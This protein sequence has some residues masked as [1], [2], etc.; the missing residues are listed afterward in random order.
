MRILAAT[1][2]VVAL[3]FSQTPAHANPY[4]SAPAYAKKAPHSDARIKPF[5]TAGDSIPLTGGTG[6]YLVVGIPD[7]LGLYRNGNHVILLSNHEFTDKQGGPVGPLPGGA[8]VSEFTLSIGKQGAEGKITVLSGKAAIDTIVESGRRVTSTKR[9]FG[10]LCSATLADHR[11]GFDRPILMTTEELSAGSTFDSLGGQA[12]ALIGGSIY[13][14]PWLGRFR[15]ENRV[16]VPFTGSKTVAF[17]LEDDDRDGQS[18]QLYMFVGEKRPGVAGALAV[19]GLDKGRLYVFAAADA[20]IHNESYFKVERPRGSKPPMPSTT[21]AT[22]NGRWMPIDWDLTDSELETTVTSRA[23]NAFTFVRVEDG[24]A[25]PRKAGEFWFVTTGEKDHPVNPF[26]RL[27]RLDFDPNDPANNP[28]RLTLALVGHSKGMV[29]P[30]NID[31]NTHG[32]IAIC[33][34]PNYDFQKDLGLARRDARFWIYNIDEKSLTAVAELDRDAARAHALAAGDSTDR[35][36]DKPGG[37]EFSGVVDAEDY[38]GRGAWILDVQAH[39]LRIRPRETVEGGQYL[40]V[41][42]KPKEPR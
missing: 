6:K 3:A 42:W 11:V 25:N 27:Y 23:V 9:R 10:K 37:W 24:A 41:I 39:S 7:G 15:G 38:L 18:S 28:A 19:N 17:S 32:E 29:S 2:M 4:A 20:S 31:I 36:K 8:R 5:L 12:Y 14:L 30:D 22:L 40:Q 13:A 26:G 21:T 35:R 33:E 34:D 16:P 1:V